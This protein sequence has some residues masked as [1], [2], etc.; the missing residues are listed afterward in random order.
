MLP[1]SHNQHR[2]ESLGAGA[3]KSLAGA[4]GQSAL[5]FST[6]KFGGSLLKNFDE[7]NILST[8]ARLKVRKQSHQDLIHLSAVKKL[9]LSPIE[10]E[11]SE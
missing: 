7:M 6:A 5:K 4:Q 8:Q 10:E 3:A 11:K 9:P 2:R 1:G